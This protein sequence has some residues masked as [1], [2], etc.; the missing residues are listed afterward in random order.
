[1]KSESSL[2]GD[3]AEGVKESPFKKRVQTENSEDDFDYAETAKKA[4]KRSIG[5]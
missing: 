2:N 4:R 3:E 1:M 5:K